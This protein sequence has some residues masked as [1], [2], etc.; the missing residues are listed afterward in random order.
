MRAIGS[1]L[2]LSSCALLGACAATPSGADTTRLQPEDVLEAATVVRAKLVQSDWLRSRDASSAPATLLPQAA[3]NRSDDRLT[4]GERWMVTAGV[5]RQPSV[6]RLLESE[7]IAVQ[8]S[9]ID[10]AL[11]ERFGV[12]PIEHAASNVPT[13]LFTAEVASIARAAA[14]AGGTLDDRRDTYVVTYQVLELPD[15]R[16]AWIGSAEFARRATGLLID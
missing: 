4:E 15:R 10:A 14:L 16:V 1:I 8:A 3:T 13:H 7:N 12:S 5:A 2:C 6:L 9:P 11:L